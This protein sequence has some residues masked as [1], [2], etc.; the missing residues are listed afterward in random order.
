MMVYLYSLYSW[1][2]GIGWKLLDLLSPG[3][4]YLLFKVLLKKLGKLTMI[5]YKAYIRYMSRVSIGERCSINRGCKILASR[6]VNDVEIVI[7]DHVLLG[8]D[9]SILAA[10]HDYNKLMVPSIAK[11]IFIG[12]HVWIGANSTILPGVHIGE[13]A[14]IGA[15]AVV[16]KDIPPYSVACGVPARVIKK[17]IIA[18]NNEQRQ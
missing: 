13:G 4:R 14:I 16:T 9:V 12:K 6:L 8:P 1:V 15:G 10:G 17:R 18:E 11:S 5:D 2:T 7:G 3:V